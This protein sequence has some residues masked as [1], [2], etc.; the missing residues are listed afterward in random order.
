MANIQKLSYPYFT[1]GTTVLG[2][3]TLNPIIAKINELVD[4][5]N[6]GVTP[7]QTVETPTISISGTTATISCSTSGA[8]IRYA[9]NGTPTESSGTFIANGGTVNLS[10]Y[11]QS[12]VIRA[13]AY[14]S[15]MT[16]SQVAQETYNPSTP[17]VQLVVPTMVLNTTAKTVALSAP[18]GLSI[19][20]SANGGTP[21]T[22][23]SSAINVSNG[24]TVKAITTN[25][26]TSSSVPKIT[27]KFN[28]EL[29]T[30]QFLS[31][32]TGDIV[33]TTDGSIPNASS[34]QYSDEITP[35]VG[36]TYKV[37]VYNNGVLASE[38]ATIQ[39][40]S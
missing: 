5:A 11:S 2:A 40:A 31:S 39:I 9:I 29:N 38:V 26:T 30:I 13:I 23:Y 8:T 14:K 18:S 6:G 16:T 36:T 22:N 7:T 35:S 15:G 4:K 33:Y 17:S 24:A 20:Y 1:D 12:T 37:A 21:A 28:E 10:S 27:V 19:K 3:S 25:G 32:Q 34:T